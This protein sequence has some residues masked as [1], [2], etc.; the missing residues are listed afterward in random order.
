MA[1]TFGLG[2][3]NMQSQVQA[4]PGSFKIQE[5]ATNIQK[6]DSTGTLSAAAFVDYTP[7]RIT[8]LGDQDQEND[9]ATVFL[10]EY[11][12]LLRSRIQ[13]MITDLTAALTTDIDRALVDSRPEWDGRMAAQG[14]TSDVEDAGAARIAY[15]F[16]MGLAQTGI[17]AGS[18]VPGADPDTVPYVGIPTYDPERGQHI[19]KVSPDTSADA[20]FAS[21][22]GVVSRVFGTA[23]IQQHFT[24]DGSDVAVIDSLRVTHNNNNVLYEETG[25]GFIAHENRW[26]FMDI[27]N[28][29]RFDTQNIFFENTSHA[30]NTNDDEWDDIVDVDPSTG[31]NVQAFDPP[32]GTTG[33]QRDFISDGFG[34]DAPDYQRFNRAG[35]VK[36]RFQ[37]T[38]YDTVFE[39]D[40]RNLLR[41]VFRLSEKNGFFTDVQIATTSSLNTG[42]Q[43]QASL[44]LNF[45]PD[46]AN[47]PDL[48]GRI[49]V[50]V[51]KFTAFYHS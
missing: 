42:S 38:L 2:T 51:D 37:Q 13:Q 41:D 26:K 3:N 11:Q 6:Y 7:G 1:F 47:R 33:N 22:G 36:N 44:L 40:N 19:N 20:Q 5:I 21:T 46:N 39:L 30:N 43:A 27:E 28:A 10:F 14:F 4:D 35:N 15:N 31:N 8:R 17:P 16:M 24:E 50:I 12:A 45:V 23:T 9:N 32:S 29:N 18:G 25:G 49:Q 34:G 48:G